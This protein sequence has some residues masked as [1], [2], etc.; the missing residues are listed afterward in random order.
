MEHKLQIEFIF[1]IPKK[2]TFKKFEF[3]IQNHPFK[4]GLSVKNINDKVFN[5]AMLKNFQIKSQPLSQKYTNNK[6][7]SIS[8]LNP[9]EIIEIWIDQMTTFISGVVW[10][11]CDIVPNDGDIIKTFQKDKHYGQIDQFEHDNQWGNH[12]FIQE[13]NELQ[14]ARTNTYILI[15]T[16]L[17]FL[18]G[19]FGLNKILEG[20]LRLLQA[21]FLYLAE[22]IGKI[23]Q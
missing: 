17:T 16:L 11:S 18:H 23:L 15:L 6:E 10:I 8:S 4:Y 21:S 13:Q 12:F 3:P 9:N 7:F 1:S 2:Y 20:F 5:G 22:V 19:T 14:Q